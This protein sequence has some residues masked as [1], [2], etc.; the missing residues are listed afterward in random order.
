MS[1]DESTASTESGGYLR[2]WRPGLR[3]AEPRLMFTCVRFSGSG[4]SVDASHALEIQGEDE[5]PAVSAGERPGPQVLTGL[6]DEPEAERIA[7]GRRNSSRTVHDS[8][9]IYLCDG[10]V[11]EFRDVTTTVTMHDLLVES[12][13]ELVATFPRHE[14]YLASDRSV[15][16]PVMF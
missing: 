10:R 5:L 8:Y 9:F 14:V 6:A 4:R 7:L 15:I 12:G 11:H 3:L 13:G 2:I 16:P 1:P